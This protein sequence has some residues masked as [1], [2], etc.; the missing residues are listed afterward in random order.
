[1]KFSNW[2]INSF[3]SVKLCNRIYHELTLTTVNFNRCSSLYIS[4]FTFSLKRCSVNVSFC[5]A[6]MNFWLSVWLHKKNSFAGCCIISSPTSWKVVTHVEPIWSCTWMLSKYLQPIDQV[7]NR[8][9]KRHCKIWQ[10]LNDILH[11]HIMGR[12]CNSTY[13]APTMVFY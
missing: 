13:P 10:T 3:S 9:P 7:L 12:T 1:M 11:C 6:S 4:S 8:N 2:D 5:I